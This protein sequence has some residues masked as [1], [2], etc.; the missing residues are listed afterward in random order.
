MIISFLL[1]AP[2]EDLKQIESKAMEV[3]ENSDPQQKDTLTV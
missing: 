3:E 2:F 1:V